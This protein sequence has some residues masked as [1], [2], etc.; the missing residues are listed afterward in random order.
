MRNPK[1]LNAKSKVIF[2]ELCKLIDVD[3]SN[4]Y[5]VTILADLISRYHQCQKEIDANGITVVS[6]TGVIRQNPATSYQLKLVP[7][8]RN[9]FSELGFYNDKPAV[10]PLAEFLG[11]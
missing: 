4:I 11:G 3:E 1:N 5:P 9:L 10:D 7:Q 6:A 8:I 2:N